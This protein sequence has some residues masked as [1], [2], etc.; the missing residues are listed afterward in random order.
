M[1]GASLRLTMRAMLVCAV[2]GVHSL[3]SAQ[4]L[5]VSFS[6]AE[7]RGPVVS[8]V[9]VD[10]HSIYGAPTDS[11]GSDGWIR[12]AAARARVI[13]NRAH[14]R[15]RR[16]FIEDE[17]LFAIGDCYDSLLIDESARIL[18]SLPFI[19]DADVY[20]IHISGDEVHVVVD[21]RDDWTLKLDVRPEFDD[22]LK[23][24]RVG[25]TEEN[26][27]GTGTLLGFYLVER[28]EKRD[29]GLELSTPRL[30]GTRADGRIG[31]GRTRTG[32]FFHES[33]T[34]PFVGEVG[35][36]AFVESY[37]LREDLFRYAAAAGSPF[38]NVSL[39]VQ[40][41]RAATTLG[42]RYGTPGNLTVLGAG[43][44]WE[45]VRFEEF[46]GDVTVVTGFD[47][48]NP[49][50]ADSATVESVRRHVNPRRMARIHLVAGK[51]NIR[52]IRRS[53]LDAIRGE[54]DIRVGTQA[55][56]TIGTTVGSP[57]AAPGN[58]SHEMRGRISLFG[59]AAGESWIFNSEL[60]IEAARLVAGTFSEETFSE[61]TFRDILGEA[62]AYFY[63]QPPA[64]PDHVFVV[65]VSGA[66][67]WNTSLPFQLTLGGP[68]GVRGYDREEF[69]A[70]QRVVAH[71]ED[72][73][74][75]SGPLRDLFDLG[76]T[77]FVDAGAGWHGTVPF[78]ADSGL[79]GTAGAGLR[80]GFPA[81]TRQI[82]RLDVAVPMR[83]SPFKSMQ[84][85][86]GYDAVSLLTGFGDRQVRRSRGANPATAILGGQF[87]R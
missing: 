31:G 32:V 45:D 20:P 52:F 35:Q 30:V 70:G 28:D 42:R 75:L 18:R 83:E 48:S 16:S 86:I 17:L 53:G 74:A 40:T 33:I 3:V 15:T 64:T 5:P 43:L 61:G 66:G 76:L 36:W 84:F 19:A 22:G 2:A 38:T 11:S 29:L 78:G 69:P 72:R 56:V 4:E 7:C 71:L 62:G 24:T 58:R 80:L 50:P 54:Q 13:A 1:T 60:T 63:W 41:R 26:L 12:S 27:G 57:S 79:Q 51:R 73:I 55:L 77:L 39:P 9:F 59:G 21:T 65:G 14:R 44:S 37:S 47:F 82:V 34:Y 10:N 25:F 68:S 81:G 6:E 46:P 85:R 8:H 23:I 49:D 87:N 67:G